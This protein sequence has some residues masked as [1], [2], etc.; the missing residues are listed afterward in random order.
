MAVVLL[1]VPKDKEYLPSAFRWWDNHERYFPGNQ[2][3][4]GLSGPPEI[5][6]KWSNPTGWLARFNWLALRNP[7]NYFQHRVLGRVR[8]SMY[9]RVKVFGDLRVGTHEWNTRGYY[10]QEVLNDSEKLWELYIVKPIYKKWHF[11][12]RAGWKLGGEYSTREVGQSLQWVF[13]ITPLKK[14]D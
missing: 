12:L 7:A 6:Q 4:D 11:R 9:D 13:A 1:F 5:R 2:S 3:D 8:S 10:Y 14:L